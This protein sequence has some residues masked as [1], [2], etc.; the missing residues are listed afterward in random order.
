MH[1]DDDFSR[2]G[3]NFDGRNLGDTLR[4]WSDRARDFLRSRRNEHWVMFFAG[5]VIGLIIG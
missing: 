4:L 3:R 2:T 5:L 1:Q